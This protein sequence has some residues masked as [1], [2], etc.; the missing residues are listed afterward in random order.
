VNATYVY[1]AIHSDR[2]PR[3]ASRAPGLPGLGGC[4][5]LDAGRGL[6]LV[7]A[8]A[9][10]P[11][12]GEA[13]IRRGLRDLDWLSRCAVAHQTVVERWLDAPAVVPMKL[14][15]IFKSDARALADIAG[16]RRRLDAVVRRVAG[17]REWG[18]RIRRVESAK[19]RPMRRVTT[20]AE[21]LA[22]KKRARDAVQALAARGQLRVDR[23]YKALSTLAVDSER[24]QPIAGADTESRLLLDAVFLVDMVK[25]QRFQAAVA[26]VANSWKTAGYRIEATG[27]WPPYN[28]IEP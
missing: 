5:V 7:V 20:G 9:P 2:P 8:D 21:Y 28:F 24:R 26:R 4:R 18:V 19:A 1:C 15:T 12:F 6:W 27:P 16:R 10:M 23:A 17:R 22:A 14:L 13:S 25:T 11:Q 3:L